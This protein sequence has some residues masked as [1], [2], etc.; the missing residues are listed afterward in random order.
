MLAFVA[1]GRLVGYAEPRMSLWDCLAAYALIEAAGGKVA[2]FGPG[3]VEGQGF[4]V[5]AAIPGDFQRLEAL[6]RFDGA[7]WVL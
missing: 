7:D 3:A 2:A 5:M 6:C 1:A 4:P